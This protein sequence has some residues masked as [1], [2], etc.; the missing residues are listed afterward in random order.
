M[1]IVLISAA[2]LAAWG[3]IATIVSVSRD[4]YRRIPTAHIAR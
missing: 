2:A 1:T 3:V 4:G